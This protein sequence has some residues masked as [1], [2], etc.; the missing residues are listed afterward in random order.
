MTLPNPEKLRELASWYR[1]FAERAGNPAI[2]NAR[3]RTAED[4]ETEAKRVELL[5]ATGP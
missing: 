4:L 2:W 3:L 1:E 5:A